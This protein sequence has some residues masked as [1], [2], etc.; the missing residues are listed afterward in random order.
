MRI[1]M[2][3]VLAKSL[4][5]ERIEIKAWRRDLVVGYLELRRGRPEADSD[6]DHRNSGQ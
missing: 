3:D 2:A 4:E 5:T 6:R 1:T